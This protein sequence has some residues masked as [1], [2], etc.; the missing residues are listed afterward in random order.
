MIFSGV[1]KG[2][3]NTVVVQQYDGLQTVYAHLKTRSVQEKDDVGPDTQIGTMGRTGNTPKLGDTH[4][5]F[6]IRENANG[7][8]LGGHTVN[9]RKYLQFPGQEHA[10]RQPASSGPSQSGE[11]PR[12]NDAPMADGVLKIG[13]RGAEVRAMQETLNRLGYTGKDGKPLETRSG[14]FGPH[15]E[16]ALKQF[17]AAHDPEADGKA[18]RKETLPALAQAVQRPLVSEKIHP[19]HSL[20]AAIQERLPPGTAPG[21][22]A[23]VTLQ[24]M[25]NGIITPETLSDMKMVGRDVWVVGTIPGESRS[26]GSGCPDRGSAAKQRPHGQT[27]SGGGAHWP[28]ADSEQ[29]HVTALIRTMWPDV[30]GHIP[31]QNGLVS[32]RHLPGR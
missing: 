31:E 29:G 20:Y 17:Q 4:L 15:T 26:G 19:A 13:E 18:G 3:G 6:E 25:E 27:E 24:A 11:R 1:M 14:M 7:V 2:Y 28:A 5:H 10:P 30:S 16:H 12:S 32:C 8:V 23:N 21:T 22:V 9:P